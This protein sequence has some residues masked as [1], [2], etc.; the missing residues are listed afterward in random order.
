MIFWYVFFVTLSYIFLWIVNFSFIS[1]FRNRRLILRNFVSWARG[2][3]A[4]SKLLAESWTSNLTITSP[5]HCCYAAKPHLCSTGTETLWVWIFDVQVKK[6]AKWKIWNISKLLC[7]RWQ[8]SSQG[9][10]IY[11]VELIRWLKDTY[12]ALQVIGGNGN[13]CRLFLY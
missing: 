9:N 5:M 4:G 1:F 12:P 13:L 3:L 7:I 2:L 8:D 11:Q 10:S 6:N